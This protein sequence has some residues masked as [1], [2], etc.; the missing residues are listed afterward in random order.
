MWFST[1][2]HAYDVLEDVHVT[3]SVRMRDDDG[4]GHAYSEFGCTTTFQG[5]GETDPK[6][7]LK[8]ALVALLETL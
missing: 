7:W 6:E 8:D 2:V 3:A 1:T 5:T 4:T